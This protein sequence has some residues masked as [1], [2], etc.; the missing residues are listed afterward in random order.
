MTPA[1]ADLFGIIRQARTNP[2]RVRGSR[3]SPSSY[4]SS[5]RAPSTSSKAI[6]KPLN[7][8]ECSCFCFII[9]AHGDCISCVH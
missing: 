6:P 3:T 9:A 1:P 4:S 2:S 5:V 8:P 7:Q